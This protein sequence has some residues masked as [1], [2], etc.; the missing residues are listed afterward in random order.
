MSTTACGTSTYSQSYRIV[1]YITHMSSV[2]RSEERR[3]CSQDIL[4][5]V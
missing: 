3:L 4:L 2:G 1:Q 5:F